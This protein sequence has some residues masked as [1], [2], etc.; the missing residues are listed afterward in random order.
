MISGLVDVQWAVV[1]AESIFGLMH[2]KDILSMDLV[3]I[4][5]DPTNPKVPLFYRLEHETRTFLARYPNGENL[6]GHLVTK[7]GLQL[8]RAHVR[9][10][11]SFIRAGT[12]VAEAFIKEGQVVAQSSKKG[13]KRKA[14]VYYDED[15][16]LMPPPESPPARGA[17]GK[18]GKFAARPTGRLLTPS[19]LKKGQKIK[20]KKLPK[21]R[22]TPG[23][24]K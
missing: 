24:A 10:V 22:V 7:L 15:I 9:A 8:G 6:A 18:L 11:Q 23:R 4:F 20:P 17:K 16:E 14:P 1:M 3:G 12:D 2:P 13:K 19:I 5:I 21:K